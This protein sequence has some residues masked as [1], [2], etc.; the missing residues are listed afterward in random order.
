MEKY[1]LETEGNDPSVIPASNGK[2]RNEKWAKKKRGIC[3]LALQSASNNP[4][5]D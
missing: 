4:L 2:A 1:D 3:S 5:E